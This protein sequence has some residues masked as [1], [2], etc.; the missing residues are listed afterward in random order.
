MTEEVRRA[1]AER[2]VAVIPSLK[3]TEK[4]LFVL[5]GLKEAGF[6]RLLVVDDG[7]GPDYAEWFDQASAIE[8][9]TVLH[10]EVN[11]GKGAALRTAF[12]YVRDEMPDA[13]GVVTADAD[14]QHLPED[15]LSCAAR[16]LELGNEFCGTVLGSRDFS[17]RD[18]PWKSRAGN[19]IT[20][21]VFK[22]CCGIPIHDTQTGLRAFP[23][24]AFDLCL[25]VSG[26][27]YEYETNVL[28]E[29]KRAGM[30]F[31]EVPIATVY[32]DNNKGSHYKPFRDSWRIY[33]LILK[34]IGSSL[35][36]S[37]ADYLIFY[38]AMHFL[39]DSVVQS[40]I[41]VSTVIARAASS[42]L[43]FNLNKT[44]VFSCKS[45]YRKTLLRYYALCIPQMLIS[46]GILT[47]LSR[48]LQHS[49]PIV[50]TLLKIPVDTVLFLLSFQIQREWVFRQPKKK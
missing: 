42:F 16:C 35:I 43:N 38:L 5:N 40:R 4:L 50:V 28:L 34:F 44:V 11:R 45:D 41:L 8:G 3:P 36:A 20:A 2:Y 10:H 17:G 15:I 31:E 27:R 21:A 47:L 12:Q 33:K 14:G 25:R 1:A 32:E 7:S 37:G 39:P 13:G 30:D 22:L 24:A 23:A 26:D 48:L 6:R 9:C 46:A 29:M 19:R 49:A 18:V